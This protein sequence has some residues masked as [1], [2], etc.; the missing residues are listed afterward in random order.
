MELSIIIEKVKN[1][2]MDGT[3]RLLGDQSSVG[4][5]RVAPGRDGDFH[6]FTPRVV[7]VCFCSGMNDL[8]MACC[9]RMPVFC[10]EGAILPAAP[11]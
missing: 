4:R 1:V 10:D 6:L 5:S 9:W 11:S 2:L 8:A 7:S 3:L